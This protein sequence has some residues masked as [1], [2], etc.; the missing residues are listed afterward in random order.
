[1]GARSRPVRSFGFRDAWRSVQSRSGRRFV[2]EAGAAALFL[3]WAGKQIVSGQLKLSKNPLY[4]P[5]LFFFVLLLAQIGLRTSAYGYVTKYEV[6]QYVSYG[7]VL[8][9]AT[10]CVREEDARKKFA[11]ALIVFGALYAFFRVGSGANLERQILLGPYGTIPWLNLRKLRQSQPLCRPD[12][13]ACADFP[14]S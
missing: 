8:L 3:V 4:A 9:I 5:A 10:E 2:F 13:D 12:G 14:W 6:L 1:M 7:I 11:L